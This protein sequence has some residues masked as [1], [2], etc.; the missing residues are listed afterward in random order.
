MGWIWR[1]IWAI[2]FLLACEPSVSENRDALAHK[3]LTQTFKSDATVTDIFQPEALSSIA[4]TLSEYS[5]IGLGETTHGQREM[6]DFRRQLTMAL[7]EMGHVRT[8]YFETGNASATYANAYI[9]GA[10]FSIDE[11]VTSG[12][13]L[14][15]WS[16]ESLARLLEDLR[17]WNA[18][19]EPQDRVTFVGVDFQSPQL[20]SQHIARHLDGRTDLDL[21]GIKTLGAELETAMQSAWSGDRDQLDSVIE[22][23][24]NAKRMIGESLDLENSDNL[25]LARLLDDLCRY[26]R[27][28]DS[29]DAR[30][31]GM[32]ES[33][34][35][36]SQTT[37][38]KGAVFWAHNGH[39]FTGPM[40]YMYSEEVAA[41]G[42]LKA[43]LG[44]DY[45]ALGFV[46]GSGRFSALVNDP[47]TGWQF[48]CYTVSD[49]VAGTLAEPFLAAGLETAFL[50]LNA[51]A[52]PEQDLKWLSQPY[53]QRGWGGY[54]VGDDPDSASRNLE[55]LV[56][57]VPMSD[58][59]GLV[60]IRST[61]ETHPHG[62]R[63]ECQNG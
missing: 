16:T 13:D 2:P 58:F 47:E 40:R 6:F 32:A 25:D 52:L 37:S 22:T 27:M 33:L 1:F 51:P 7:I 55:S 42:R 41:G 12:L 24:N 63:L 15:I 54:N 30:D 26:S 4:E 28:A 44:D 45:Y 23:I 56:T 57:T 17:R 21:S 19:A 46:F 62:K 11:A 20:T 38:S 18:A 53:P 8:V 34:L 61:S 10:D 43:A 29:A 49:P 35:Q 48:H 36:D 14:L 50:D 60:F 5:L 31:A 59:D 39:V 3:P 9:Q